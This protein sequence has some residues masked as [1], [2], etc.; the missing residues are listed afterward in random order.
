MEKASIDSDDLRPE[1]RGE[2]FGVMVRGKYAAR[3]RE[4][5]KVVVL[6]P[7]VAKAFPNGQAVNDALRGL[8]ELARASTRLTTKRPQVDSQAA[9]GE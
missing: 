8:I 9:H 7:D 4:S 5:S 1:Y 3:V 6:D 2:D